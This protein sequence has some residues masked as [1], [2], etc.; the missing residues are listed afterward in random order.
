MPNIPT[1]EVFTSPDRRRADG[2]IRVTKPMVI[3]GQLVTGL[4]VTF[5][6]AG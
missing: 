5:P 2:V 4:R 1:E 6:A 3:A